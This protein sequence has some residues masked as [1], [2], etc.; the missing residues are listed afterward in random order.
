MSCSLQDRIDAAGLPR[1]V[2]FIFCVAGVALLW[3]TSS[4]T[5]SAI[6][7][8]VACTYWRTL[9][10]P[11]EVR[12]LHLAVMLSYTCSRLSVSLGNMPCS[13]CAW[14]GRKGLG[15]VSPCVL[16]TPVNPLIVGV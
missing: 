1:T 8:F 12:Y 14:R 15:H 5:Q 16:C 9:L 3:W 6:G 13:M 2:R 4:F 10:A 11:R 7:F